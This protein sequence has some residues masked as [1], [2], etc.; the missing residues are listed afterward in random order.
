MSFLAIETGARVKVVPINK[1]IAAVQARRVLLITMCCSR[2]GAINQWVGTTPC[3]IWHGGCP[4]CAAGA[5]HGS[6][7]GS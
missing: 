4:R 6:F 1:R 3:V 7:T 5:C 2:H